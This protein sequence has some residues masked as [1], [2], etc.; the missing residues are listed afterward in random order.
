MACSP[1]SR[2]ISAAMPLEAEV[3]TR[4]ASLSNASSLGA[5]CSLVLVVG[6][7]PLALFGLTLPAWNHC[8]TSHKKD[9]WD[10]NIFSSTILRGE[11]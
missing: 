1:S 5:E 3:K 7:V 9:D 2:D 8:L 10:S 4:Q 6:K 11:G